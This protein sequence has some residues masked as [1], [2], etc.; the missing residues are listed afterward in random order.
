VKQ[1]LK[2]KTETIRNKFYNY[3]NY[4]QGGQSMVL[5]YHR[6]CSLD[7]D[8]QMLSITPENF[9]DQVS[10]LKKE[11]V[12]L[13]ADEFADFVTRNK[14]LPPKSVLLTFDDGYADNFQIALPILES[15]G[16]QALFFITTSNIDTTK[17]LWWDELERVFLTTARLPEMIHLKTENNS[18]FKTGS[19]MDRYNVYNKLHPK[20]KY[21]HFEERENMLSDFRTWAG[22]TNTGRETHRLMTWNEAVKMSKSKSAV[23][24][25]HSV[26]HV[27]LSVINYNEQL[28]EIKD[29]KELLESRLQLPVKYFSYPYG[30]KKD[31][32]IDTVNICKS[33]DFALSF[34]NFPGY[35]GR[36]TDRFQLPRV[37]V[38]N[39]N[40]SEFKT[41]LKIF[42]G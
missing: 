8:P 35:I 18:S 1:I 7:S 39:I 12:L 10:F 6:V 25:A 29:S 31:Y 16:A 36:Y 3:W 17:E 20:I 32:T 26:H 13:T 38:R 33:L 21:S 30:A 22:I 4:L 41:H 19:E 24:G 37:L 40:L 11:Y 27:P 42:H 5:L 15:L 14:S 34:S 9:Y 23:I 28:K 2:K